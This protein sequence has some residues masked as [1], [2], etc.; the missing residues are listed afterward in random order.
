MVTYPTTE[1]DPITDYYRVLPDGST[2]L[3]SDG[4]ADAFGDGTWDHATCADPQDVLDI[5]C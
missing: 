3:W 2:E 1:G 5:A 4:T